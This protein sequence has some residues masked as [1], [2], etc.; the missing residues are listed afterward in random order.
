[1]ILWT[2][3]YWIYLK[4]ALFKQRL[5]LGGKVGLMVSFAH[6]APVSALKTA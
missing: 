5:R 3:G 2:F 6:N 4:I 1:M